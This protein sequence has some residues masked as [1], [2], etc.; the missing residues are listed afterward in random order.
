MLNRLD[1]SAHIQPARALIA[2]SLA[3]ALSG[4][5]SSSSDSPVVSTPGSTAKATF[6]A[7]GHLS[8]DSTSIA[9]AISADGTVV[10]GTSYSTTGKS[11][12]FR[13]TASGGMTG[14]GI[15]SGGTLSTA[16]GVSADGS[17]IVGGTDASDSAGNQIPFI[18]KAS[19]GMAP[20]SVAG[21]G[22][23]C[24]ANGASSDGSVVVGVCANA[25]QFAFRWTAATG[26]TG[27]GQ[28]FGSGPF[29]KYLAQ[30]VSADGSKIVG[31][32]FL[33]TGRYAPTVW[34]APDTA[35]LLGANLTNPAGGATAVSRDG[36]VVAGYS[37][38]ASAGQHAFRWTSQGGMIG[39]DVAASFTQS[40]VWAMSGDG[41]VI[42]GSA[43]QP[44][45]E[46]ATLWNLQ[47]GTRTLDVVLRDDYQTAVPAGWKLTRALG[48]SADGST[49]VGYGTNPA[50]L[51]EGWVLKLSQ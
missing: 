46:T 24:S 10:V 44:A 26:M 35:S 49:L 33:S 31:T 37:L 36:S 20:I 1:H 47:H 5:G 34:A 19:Q 30:A 4:C 9:S 8:G 50:G 14:L 41:S 40:T 28:S 2:L 48:I 11:Q 12:A 3:A 43:N 13:W 23:A 45:A 51:P 21:S 39:L 38:D 32:V 16:N 17:V 7:L 29:P 27:L 18:W 25:T 15:L 22:F 6:T 42:V